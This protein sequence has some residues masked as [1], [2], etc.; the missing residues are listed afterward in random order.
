MIVHVAAT[1][2]S[3]DHE[4]RLEGGPCTEQRVEANKGTK[5][6]TGLLYGQKYQ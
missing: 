3:L 5:S 2:Q 6:F 1:L 4:V